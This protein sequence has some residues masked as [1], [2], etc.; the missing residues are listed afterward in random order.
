VLFWGDGD[1][2]FWLNLTVLLKLVLSQTKASRVN[3]G[4]RLPYIQMAGRS[5]QS[6]VDDCGVIAPVAVQSQLFWDTFHIP[7]SR[8]L[9]ILAGADTMVKYGIEECRCLGAFQLWSRSFDSEL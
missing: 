4:Q 7:A 3:W 5:L 2:A 1:L 8:S 9:Y 6:T